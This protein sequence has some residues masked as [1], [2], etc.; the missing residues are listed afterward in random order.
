MRLE[1]NQGELVRHTDQTDKEVGVE[2]GD[3]MRLHI[4]IKTNKDVIFNV[5]DTNNVK[6]E[7]NMDENP[8]LSCGLITSEIPEHL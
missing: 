2:I 8:K 7:K 5:W 1:K 6:L 3:I 4:P